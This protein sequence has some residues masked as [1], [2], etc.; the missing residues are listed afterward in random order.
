MKRDTSKQNTRYIQVQ[1]C[2][3]CSK[4]FKTRQ[5]SRKTSPVN[6]LFESSRGA[7]ILQKQPVHKSLSKSDGPHPH[8]IILVNPASGAPGCHSMGPR[9]KAALQ[10]GGSCASAASFVVW[11]RHLS[12]HS[13][14]SMT[15]AAAATMVDE[16]A[17]HL[18]IH[19]DNMTKA[20]PA[21]MIKL[22]LNSG[23]QDEA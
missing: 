15:K 14:D 2:Y 7:H 12:I 19:P 23:H 4:L 10:T 9:A 11:A 18:R 17:R 6:Q 5:R 22:E 8:L 16:R 3:H 13:K 20:D 21:T 1:C